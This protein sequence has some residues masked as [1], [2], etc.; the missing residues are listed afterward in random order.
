MAGRQHL[1]AVLVGLALV[2]VAC[3]GNDT[4]L[5]PET[6]P[7]PPPPP[8]SLPPSL[9][10]PSDCPAEHPV[11]LH[12]S[13]DTEAEVPYLSSMAACTT[14][15]N[16]QTLIINNNDAVWTVATDVPASVTFG[17]DTR[18]QASF[19][20][21]A[22]ERYPYALLL[23]ES[24]VVVH[25]PPEE[26]RW[27]LEPGFT[28]MWLTYETLLDVIEDAA[29][30]QVGDALAGSSLR[31]RALWTC[32]TAAY[33]FSTQ[34][35]FHSPDPTRALLA[36]LG[37]ATSGTECARAWMAADDQARQLGRNTATWGSDVAQLA[38]DSRFVSQADDVL[39]R[40]ARW[41]RA[42]FRTLP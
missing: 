8:P 23:P 21:M 10:P 13:S 29:P 18:Q 42:V 33:D 41:A 22:S 27:G 5:P 4:T 1:G 16:D 15:S 38:D 6:Y 32:A 9:P 24:N 28:S 14:A 12:L 36:R 11:A 37:V 25:A 7:P 19:R 17:V 31:R 30:D 3:G 34:D 35:D 26:V 2:L 39:S 40:A 20:D